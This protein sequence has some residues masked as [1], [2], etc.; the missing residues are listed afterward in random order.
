MFQLHIH[1]GSR[2]IAQF[3]FIP[4]TPGSL[5]G[6]FCT[7]SGLVSSAT[8]AREDFCIAWNKELVERVYHHR[9]CSTISSD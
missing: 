5:E 2:A 6:T 3:T 1:T 4:N 8:A 9:T 7:I